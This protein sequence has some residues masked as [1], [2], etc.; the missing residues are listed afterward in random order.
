LSAFYPV[1]SQSELPARMALGLSS[2]EADS[3]YAQK[4]KKKKRRATPI[5]IAVC[6]TVQHLTLSGP[7]LA[8]F[9]VLNKLNRS[10]L[11]YYS[12]RRLG[13]LRIICLLLDSS[14]TWIQWN[15]SSRLIASPFWR[16]LR[17]KFEL[18][19]AQ[20]QNHSLTHLLP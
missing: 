2:F 3:K 20:K 16:D 12:T 8:I 15:H 19:F 5:F 14:L 6:D 18:S 10:F 13:L 1:G 17:T 9:L 4:K 11:F 7:C